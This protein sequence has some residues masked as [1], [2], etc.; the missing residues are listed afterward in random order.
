MDWLLIGA[1]LTAFAILGSARLGHCIRVVALQGGLLSLLSL[2][3]GGSFSDPHRLFLGAAS[4]IIK[5]I[6]IPILLARSLGKAKIK[7]EVEPTI[8]PHLSLLGG[9]VLLVV[10]FL[11]AKAFPLPTEP[12]PALIIPAALTIIFIGFFLLVSRTKALTQV[13]GFLVLE[14]G[15]FLFGMTLIG[16]FPLTV[17]LGV[18]LDLLVGVFVM[19]IMIYHINKTFDHIDTRALALLKDIEE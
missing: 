19:G 7:Q 6:V 15:I 11:S 4:F 9:G 16:E 5:T 14:N 1:L 18:F 10:A 13:I 8:S 17:E 2:S 12:F 3:A